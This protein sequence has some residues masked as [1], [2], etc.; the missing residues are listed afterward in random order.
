MKWANSLALIALAA[1]S[2]AWA[3]EATNLSKEE[4]SIPFINL[5]STIRTWQA[6]GEKGL[7]IQDQ[8]KNWYY[9]QTFGRCEG[10]DFAPR[11]GFKTKSG[12]ALD[13]FGEIVVPNYDRCPLRSLTRSEE[14]PKGKRN[15]K[16]EEEK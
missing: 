8:H 12:S 7:W 2:P 15:K 16:V 14:P 6:D 11:L 10:L 1:S 4:V 9:A 3:E 5:D 13:R